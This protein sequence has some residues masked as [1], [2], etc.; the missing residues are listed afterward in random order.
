MDAVTVLTERGSPLMGLAGAS[1][2]YACPAELS[3]V[4]GFG[5]CLFVLAA[6]RAPPSFAVR[7]R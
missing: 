4:N 5:F 7:L 6:N 2:R 3:E 1:L